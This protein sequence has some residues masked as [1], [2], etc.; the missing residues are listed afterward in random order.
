[1]LQLK[2]RAAYVFLYNAAD[3]YR[4]CEMKATEMLKYVKELLPVIYPRFYTLY[5]ENLDEL[6]F[7]DTGTRTKPDKLDIPTGKPVT[8][9]I[10]GN[11]VM[12]ALDSHV[13]MFEHV[14]AKNKALA[15]EIGTCIAENLLKSLCEA[16]PEKKFVVY[17]SINVTDSCIVRF[18]Q[19]WEGEVPYYD[20]TKFQTDEVQL[21][22]FKN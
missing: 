21:F 9:F 3:N 12:E 20:I 15:V 14:G 22:E 5:N 2:N 16:F 6:V 8:S 17:L 19:V 13:H 18:H 1:M 10:Y 11:T 4:R 7:L